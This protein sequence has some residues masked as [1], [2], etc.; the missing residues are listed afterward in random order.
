[1]THHALTPLL[2][3]ALAGA[4]AFANGEDDEG[5]PLP[6]APRQQTAEPAADLPE[7]EGT[8]RLSGWQR[9]PVQAFGG[10]VEVFLDGDRMRYTRRQ[11]LGTSGP[12]TVERGTVLQ[13]G[14]S[15]IFRADEAAAE[16]SGSGFAQVLRG[17]Q[18]ETQE[19]E[20]QAPA[21]AAYRPGD[22]RWSGIRREDGGAAKETLT[23]WSGEPGN[24]LDLLIDGQAFD[25]FEEAIRGAKRTIDVQM[26]Q[27]A[28]D[29]TG[30]GIAELLIAKA[31]EGVRVRCLVDA[32]SPTVN[33]MVSFHIPEPKVDI[34]GKKYHG[35]KPFPF[36]S[37]GQSLKDDMEDGGVEVIMAHGYLEGFGN[38]VGGMFRGIGNWVGGLFGR[39]APKREKR[40]MSN[41]DHRKILI[42]DESIGF[43]GGMNIARE[44]RYEWHDVVARVEG[45]AAHDLHEAFVDRWQAAGGEGEIERE[46]T[47]LWETP[48]WDGDAEVEVIGSL[49]GLDTNLK[50]RYIHEIDSAQQRILIEMAYFLDDDIIA[51]LGRAA[52]RGVRTVV[53]VPDDR[54][55]DVYLV[56]EAFAWVHNDVLRAGIELYFYQPRLNHSKVA[57]FDGRVATVGSCTL[58]AMALEMLAEINVWVDDPRFARQL[59]E[60]I[61]QTDLP[62]CERAKPIEMGWGRKLRSRTLHM[63]RGWL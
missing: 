29:E 7:I 20:P 44:Y 41:H 6:V 17:E 45:P 35:Y 49:P 23:R 43:C 27:W 10:K 47:E 57:S 5:L 1:M 8:W 60:R 18:T 36:A 46:P 11:R 2:L 30:R 63:M 55:N 33:W 28:D 4:T 15:L 22:A 53:I 24:H 52:Q 61:F 19:T 40:G 25:A 62:Q 21:I 38:S 42:V 59:D 37:W 9:E 50:D 54:V 56:K 31:Q 14:P 13:R 58:D 39:E 3:V 12:A 32:S 16:P 51:A 34:T 48:E 26:F